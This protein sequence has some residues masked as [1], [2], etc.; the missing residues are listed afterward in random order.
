[1][2]GS[3]TVKDKSSA[4]FK[5]LQELAKKTVLVGIPE[6]DSVRNATEL[7]GDI[8]NAQ[9]AYIHTHG[10]RATS[11]RREMDPEISEGRKYSEAYTMYM[12]EHGSPLWHSPPRPIIETAIE[13][14]SNR[15]KI[16]NELKKVASLIA[17][18]DLQAAE[19][20]LQAVGMVASSAVR[21]WFENSENGWE[22]NAESTI[23]SKGSARP[24][25]DTG[26]L[27]NSITY[28]IRPKE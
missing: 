3:M 14:P 27:R 28:V 12:M 22:P 11:M 25:V 13:H 26:Q 5:E 21:D 9:L 10:V 6:S 1:M 17:E 4:M 23:K 7:R 8:S 24:L 19:N 18:G 2:Y 16:V 20:Q 15:E